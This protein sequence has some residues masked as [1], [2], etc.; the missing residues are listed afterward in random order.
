[1]TLGLERTQDHIDTYDAYDTQYDRNTR[2]NNAVFGQWLGKE[3]GFNHQL[4][5]RY[6]NNQQFGDEVTGT[7]VLGYTVAPW[8]SP[9]ISYGT[10]FVTPTFLDLYYPGYSNPE[11]DPEKGGPPNWA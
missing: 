4:S 5:L 9:Y 3:K 1:M 6:D 2:Y 11:L 7:A 10:A 8:L